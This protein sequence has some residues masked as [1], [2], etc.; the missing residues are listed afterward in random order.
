MT[1]LT[2]IVDH[3]W[4]ANAPLKAP[5]LRLD[6]RMTVVRLNSGELMV[7]SPVPYSEQLRNAL[8]ELGVPKWFVAPSLHHDLYWGE[9]FDAFPGSRFAAPQ[10]MRE[11]HAEF[12]FT[13]L[14]EEHANYWDGELIPIAIRGMPKIHE[15]V[16]LHV[17][18]RTLIVADLVFNL[19]ADAQNAFGRLFLR[20]NGIYRRPGISRI[21]R[22]FVED[23]A[24]FGDSVREILSH[25]FDRTIIGHGPNLCGTDCLAAIA[26]RAGVDVKNQ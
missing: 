7:H 22:M 8:C 24:A 4:E 11:Q 19:D 6:H 1:V 2:R 15:H 13:D 26:R 18:S 3:I 5:G 25:Q 20:M 10:G 12:P 9:W 14:L 16:L 23:K 17:T 21:F